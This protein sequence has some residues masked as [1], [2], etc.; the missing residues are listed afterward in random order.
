[1]NMPIHTQ[2]KITPEE[3]NLFKTEVQTG[4]TVY[5]AALADY[6]AILGSSE[7]FDTLEKCLPHLLNVVDFKVGSYLIPFLL[8]TSKYTSFRCLGLHALR[9]LLSPAEK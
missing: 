8:H 9:N 1:M 5:E 3:L 4:F 2:L 7:L 6:R